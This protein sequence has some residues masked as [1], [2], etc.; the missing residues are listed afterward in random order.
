MSKNTSIYL[1]HIKVGFDHFVST[2]WT[3]IVTVKSASTN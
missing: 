2:Y 1:E 3:Q